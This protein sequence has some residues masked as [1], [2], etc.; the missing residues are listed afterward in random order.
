MGEDKVNILTDFHHGDLYYSLHLLFEER[1]GAKLFRPIGLDWFTKGFFKM[2]E[3]YGNA[4]DTIKQFLGV[5]PIDKPAQKYSIQKYKETQLVDDVYYIPTKVSNGYFNQRAITF[6]KFLEMDFDFII[7][8][9]LL[10]Y[11]AY[12]ELTK[13]HKPDAT[14]IEQIGN[15]GSRPS[16]TH[17]ALVAT[18]EPMPP[19]IEYVR[20]HPEHH[21]DYCYTP[22]TNHKLIKTF[23]HCL[24]QQHYQLSLAWWEGY[25]NLIPELT[26]RMHGI[27][28][29]DGVIDNYKMPEAIKDSS[30]VWHVKQTGC[31]GFTPRQSMACGRPVIIKK[32]WADRRRAMESDIYEDSI[33]CIDLDSGSTEQN[34]EKIKYFTDTNNH[35]ELCKSTARSFKEKVNFDKEAEI[36]KKFLDEIRNL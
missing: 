32:S 15:I 9:H 18:N 11:E 23:I 31:E 34:V 33:N 10:N 14:Y 20:Y 16:H 21:K 1:L 27:V 12:A 2:A 13:K 8:S 24:P 17:Y 19:N 25:K 3:P 29:D 5:P 28:G 22:P 7:A 4:P 6:K 30:L 36:I 26:W 35:V